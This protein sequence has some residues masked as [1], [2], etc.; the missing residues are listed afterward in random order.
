MELL[1]RLLL[2]HFLCDFILQPD[3]W[4]EYKNEIKLRSYKLYVHALIYGTAAWLLVYD[5]QFWKQALVLLISHLFIDMI[6]TLFQQESTKRLWFFIDQL[7]HLSVIFAIALTAKREN[8]DLTVL[9][10]LKTMVVLTMLIFITKPASVIIRT[11]ISKWDFSKVTEEQVSL[12]NAG[13][14]IGILE[15]LLAFAFICLNQWQGVGFLI[16]AK[17]VFRFGDIKNAT[18]RKMTEY[19]I[20]GSFLSYGLA[21][22]A[23]IITQWILKSMINS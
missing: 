21:V 11:V 12:K 13:E 1:I 20:I 6:K 19:F 18:D 4:I 9:W 8:I 14:Y 5:L 7:M 17:S 23:G 10:N 2:A 3:R 16:T 22:L 15:R